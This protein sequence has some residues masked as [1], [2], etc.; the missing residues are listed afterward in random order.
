LLVAGLLLC[1]GCGEDDGGK[2]R[3]RVFMADSLSRPLK[4]LGKAFVEENPDVELVESPSGSV[5]AARKLSDGGDVCDVLAVADYMVIDKLLRPDHADWYICFATNEIGIVYTDASKGAADINAGNWFRV[6]AQDGVRVA[7]ADPRH[8]PCG[9][10]AEL[11]WGLADLHYPADQRDGSVV[12]M[13]TAKCGPAEDRRTDAQQLMRL[14]EAAGGIDYAFVYR[15]Q[16]LQHNRLFLQ[17]PAEIN[18]GDPDHVALYRQA[19]MELPGAKPGE[20]YTKRGEAIVFAVTIPKEARQAELAA[21]Y[22]AFML[23]DKGR[24]ILRSHHVQALDEP[25]TYDV[26]RVPEPLRS[27]LISRDR[28]EVASTPADGTDDQ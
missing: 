18:L 28:D 8:D 20:T 4:A 26:D 14:V 19:H 5:L 25:I 21:R 22:V 15:S 16:A 17:L 1:V 11:C 12:E 27:G 9:Y 24:S 6:L 13:M 23:G 2:T 10:W 7:A 3:L